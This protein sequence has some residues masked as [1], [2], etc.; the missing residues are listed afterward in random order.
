MPGISDKPVTDK[1]LQF[2]VS[3][4]SWQVN[5]NVIPSFGLP[6]VGRGGLWLRKADDF[7]LLLLSCTSGLGFWINAQQKEK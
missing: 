1:R 2:L 4:A 6:A 7:S 3:W 5:G